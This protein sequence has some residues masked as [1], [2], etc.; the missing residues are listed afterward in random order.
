MC[1]T[2]QQG[3][4]GAASARVLWADVVMSHPGLRP[5]GPTGQRRLQA[6]WQH[7][8]SSAL[9][10]RLSRGAGEPPWERWELEGAQR[11]ALAHQLLLLED[12]GLRVLLKTTTVPKIPAHTPTPA[13]AWAAACG[14]REAKQ[15]QGW[16]QGRLG[17]TLAVA[18][19]GPSEANADR[20]K[21][22]TCRA[23]GS[24]KGV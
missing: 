18:A 15:R 17:P 14:H 3:L 7:R 21:S 23:R 10:S 12:G 20:R 13:A 2:R 9:P 5:W 16:W 24:S 4:S 8:Q 22:T 11:R 6:G 19:L 1:Q